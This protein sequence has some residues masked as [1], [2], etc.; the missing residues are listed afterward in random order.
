MGGSAPTRELFPQLHDR[1][2]KSP[3][4][5][6]YFFQ[7][8]WAAR[9]IAEASPKRHVDVGSRVDLVAFL[10][11]ITD[12]VFVDIRPLDAELE[13]LSSVEGSVLEL[14]FEDSSLE[15][16][17]CLHVAEHIGLGRYGDALDPHGTEKAAQELSR[18]LAPGG[19]L[20]FCLPV[21]RSR[22]F[23]NAHRVHQP[24][25]VISMFGDLR[26]VEFAGVDDVGT[27]ARFRSPKELERCD[28]AC[29]MFL[30]EKTS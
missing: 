1:L 25:E 21:G 10:T 13:G 16:V 27:F 26:L 30:F 28:Y 8:A 17:S 12:V 7:D 3:F 18:V 29:G 15:S 11:S 19:R 23:F 4:D 6:H 2:A 9:R 14:P 5:P 24:T 20:L 22:T